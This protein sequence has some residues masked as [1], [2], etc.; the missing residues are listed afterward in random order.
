[1]SNG[2]GSRYRPA[3][4]ATYRSAWD[5]IFGLAAADDVSVAGW[6]GARRGAVAL[7]AGRGVRR[8]RAA[9]GAAR[10][11]R[12]AEDADAPDEPGGRGE[13]GARAHGRGVRAGAAGVGRAHGRAARHGVGTSE[14][15][16]RARIT[17]AAF[18]VPGPGT[19]R[20]RLTRYVRGEQDTATEAAHRASPVWYLVDSE[21]RAA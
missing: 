11:T 1:V 3:N 6:G 19:A 21:R 2:K 8:L 14:A 5:R 13:R 17:A 16:V 12:R 10:T 7:R 18:R 15:A 4:G 9:G 20:A